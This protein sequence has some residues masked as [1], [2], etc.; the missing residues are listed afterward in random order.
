[1]YRYKFQHELGRLVQN[2]DLRVGDSE[3]EETGEQLRRAHAEGRL[4]AEEFQQRIE[5]CYKAKT[6]GDL[7]ALV[8]DL[9]G[10][11][12]QRER[13]FGRGPRLLPRW[14]AA[15]PI[16]LTIFVIAAVI[17]HHVF[18]VLLPLFFV[19]RFWVWRRR[20]HFGI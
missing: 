20:P 14:G 10:E 15:V 2:P 19:M 16:L 1:M 13:S 9:P 18:W 17:H 5:R 8:V 3:R 6:V 11:P 4:D 7:R 12:R